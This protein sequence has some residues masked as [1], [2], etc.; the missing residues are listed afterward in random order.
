MEQIDQYKSDN[1]MA[2]SSKNYNQF[3]IFVMAGYLLYF[4]VLAY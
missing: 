3:R 4:F 2:K 1:K